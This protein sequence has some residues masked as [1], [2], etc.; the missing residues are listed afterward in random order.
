M[1]G[2][3]VGGYDQDQVIGALLSEPCGKYILLIDLLDIEI[4]IVEGRS[5]FNVTGQNE[6]P[7]MQ[8]LNNRS[9]LPRHS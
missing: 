8:K 1:S 6:P 5:P 9:L 4:G 3:N 2:G 7:N